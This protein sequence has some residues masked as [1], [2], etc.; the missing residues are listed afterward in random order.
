MFSCMHAISVA[1][2]ECHVT[3]YNNFLGSW[4][5]VTHH[6]HAE[7]VGWRLIPRLFPPNFFHTTFR[8][9]TGVFLKHTISRLG[10]RLKPCHVFLQHYHKSGWSQRWREEDGV[11]D[12]GRKMESKMEGRRWS[13]RWRE[14]D[15]VKDG[16][17]KME[18]KMVDG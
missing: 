8:Q 2:F 16:G 11:K 14:E 4:H 10:M 17:K 3:I 18:S 13:Q 5:K 1:I 15:G 9:C 7:E 6:D 12:G